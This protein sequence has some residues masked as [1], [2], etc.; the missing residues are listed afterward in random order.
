MCRT[1]FYGYINMH[2]YHIIV[3][4]NCAP[5]NAKVHDHGHHRGQPMHSQ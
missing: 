1:V 4:F 2:E 5:E 3:C